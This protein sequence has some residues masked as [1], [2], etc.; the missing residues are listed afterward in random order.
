MRAATRPLHV[1]VTA[2]AVGGVWSYAMALCRGLLA[3]G[4]RVTLA[5]L[6]PSPGAAQRLE[7]AALPGLRLLDTRLPLDWMSPSAA[8]VRD[9]GRQLAALVRESGAELLHLNSPALAAGNRF[10]VPV[11]AFCHSCLASWWDAVKAGPLPPEFAWH[12][13]LLAEGYGGA[14]L[15]AAPSRA[16]ADATR[17]LYALPERPRTVHNGIPPLALPP[18]RA[19]GP[20]AFTAG[21][22]WDEGKNLATLDAAAAGLPIPFLAAGPLEGPGGAHAGLRHLLAQGSLDRPAMQAILARRPIF[23]SAARYEPFGLAVLEAA[24]AGCPLVLSD[25]PTF[26]EIW[27]GAA[28]YVPSGDAAGFAEALRRLAASPRL[29]AARGQAAR[30]RAARYTAEAM[31]AETLGLYR[32]LVPAPHALEAPA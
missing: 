22:L 2:D 30:L 24:Q 13:E 6:G 3:G 4:T 7:A 15:L 27:G 26:R 1:L 25:I 32:A 5:V 20:F 12:R 28:D 14:D 31:A 8:A 19:E 29:R 9:S 17:T 18:A 10:P 23:A 21:R 16:F 11:L